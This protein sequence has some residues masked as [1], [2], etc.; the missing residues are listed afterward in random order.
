MKKKIKHL[1]LLFFTIGNNNES[2]NFIKTALYTS[3][4]IL[5]GGVA[6]YI[7]IEF[8]KE[9]SITPIENIEVPKEL[10]IT[11]KPITSTKDT[12]KKVTNQSIL[13]NKNNNN[14][15]LNKQL[16]TLIKNIEVTKELDITKTPIISNKDTTPEINH[17]SVVDNKINNNTNLN[18]IDIIK[19]IPIT[20][21]KNKTSEIIH[22]PVIL[23]KTLIKTIPEN[24]EPIIVVPE[25]K[26]LDIVANENNN[27][28]IKF[29]DNEEA[30][31][32]LVDKNKEIKKQK[33]NNMFAE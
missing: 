18:K 2:L 8:K 23:N 28:K 16:I 24:L 11:K 17:Q 5:V 20:F 15:D 13:S 22:Q 19:K 12:T 3:T 4:I 7:I 27:S 21:S 31:L 29:I 9:P 25:N 32:E 30:F 6:R 26:N 1:L 10:Y 33:L 14:G